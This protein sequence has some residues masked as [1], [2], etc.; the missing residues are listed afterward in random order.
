M[1]L[2]FSV[3]D[4]IQLR[5]PL[6]QPVQLSLLDALIKHALDA[7]R[8]RLSRQFSLLSARIPFLSLP[9]QTWSR[10]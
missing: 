9:Y 5:R 8:G 3:T 10:W 6:V 2:V 4:L 7:F 1:S